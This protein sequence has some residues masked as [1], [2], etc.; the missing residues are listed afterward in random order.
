MAMSSVGRSARSV[1][2]F[3]IA[4][5]TSS[6]SS[7]SPNTV[8][9]PSRNGVPPITVSLHLLC[10]EANGILLAY[11]LRLFHKALLHLLRS[12]AVSVLAHLHNLL[13]VV[14]HKVVEGDGLLVLL[15]LLLHLFELSLVVL[16]A[17]HDV[18]LAAARL[19]VGVHL[20]A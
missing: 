11:L 8:Y 20:V 19:L 4:S 14:G 5:T 6:P 18:E 7:T 16:L 15:H 12:G 2:T 10:A 9:S 13:L 3:C 1:S 17:E